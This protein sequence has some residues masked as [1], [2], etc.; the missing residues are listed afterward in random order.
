MKTIL[1][2]LGMATVEQVVKGGGRTLRVTVGSLEEMPDPLES[3]SGR[4]SDG[5]SE[6]P[7]LEML[8]IRTKAVG[9]TERSRR[10]VVE[11]PG[12]FTYHVVEESHAPLDAYDVSDDSGVLRVL[13]RSRYVDFVRQAHMPMPFMREEGE[14]YM[15]CLISDV[16]YVWSEGMPTFTEIGASA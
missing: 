14:F 11:F 8:R 9:I 5:I 6:P 7:V 1:D 12:V 13:E 2:E 10:V 15:L 3:P 4:I 16:I